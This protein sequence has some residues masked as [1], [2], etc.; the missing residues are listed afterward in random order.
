MAL[1]GFARGEQLS[2]T[3]R[4]GCASRCGVSGIWSR[5][6]PLCAESRTA[7][8]RC[9]KPHAKESVCHSRPDAFTTN[10]L[11]PSWIFSDFPPRLQIHIEGE[12]GGYLFLCL[13]HHPPPPPPPPQ[14]P[15]SGSSLE[16]FTVEG[17]KGRK[18][19]SQWSVRRSLLQLP[20]FSTGLFKTLQLFCQNIVLFCMLCQ[21][22]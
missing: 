9:L 3:R 10:R 7:A 13:Y 16:M 21:I 8:A 19:P 1:L 2:R 17:K 5:A 22:D 18:K 15:P 6:G 14:H 12:G 4:K 11:Q 20:Q